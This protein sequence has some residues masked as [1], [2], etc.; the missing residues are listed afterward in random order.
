MGHQEF[1]LSLLV[2]GSEGNG[3]YRPD[4]GRAG[5]RTVLDG[6][7]VKGSLSA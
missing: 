2:L 1:A 7:A 4:A 5:L 3:K 6:F